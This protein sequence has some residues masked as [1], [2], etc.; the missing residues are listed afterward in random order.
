MLWLLC[1]RCVL[2]VGNIL[3]KA[4]GMQQ[5]S[6]RPGEECPLLL[7]TG[8]PPSVSVSFSLCVCVSL[9]VS[10]PPSLSLSV[11]SS[12]FSSLS[13]SLSLSLSRSHT[14]T[15]ARAYTHTRANTRTRTRTNT[16]ARTHARTHTHTHTPGDDWQL[17]VRRQ[18]ARM[19][20]RSARAK[21]RLCSGAGMP[22]ASQGRG[23][24]TRTSRCC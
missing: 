3:A 8:L 1:W 21:A 17:Q 2:Y 12:F 13:L 15:H 10:L 5:H 22:A 20:M 18:Y 4:Q 19:S 6:T 24:G 11:L 7:A 14:I 9:S 16:H 23:P